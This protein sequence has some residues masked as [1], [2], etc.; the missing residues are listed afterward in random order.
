[1]HDGDNVPLLKFLVTIAEERAMQL[2]LTVSVKRSANFN[3]RILKHFLA[4]QRPQHFFIPCKISIVVW[5]FNR[6]FLICEIVLLCR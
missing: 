2:P 5:I 3:K 1:M 6:I 4:A